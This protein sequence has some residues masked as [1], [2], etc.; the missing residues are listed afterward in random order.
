[1]TLQTSLRRSVENK[2]LV[3]IL[4]ERESA[5]A[6]SPMIEVIYEVQFPTDAPASIL[7][8]NVRVL[9]FISATRTDTR[10]TVTLTDEET[11]I[12]NSRASEKS[13]DYTGN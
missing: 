13:L 2:F 8:D 11:E 9:R 5:E 12:C 6:D 7:S 4:F 10:A 1:M 3:V